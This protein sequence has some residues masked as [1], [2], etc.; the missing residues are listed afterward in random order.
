MFEEIKKKIPKFNPKKFNVDFELAVIKA[1]KRVFPGAHIQGCYFHF[2]KNVIHNIGQHNLKKR[3]EDDALFAHEVRKLTSLAFVPTSK[4]AEVFDHFIESSKIFKEKK[5]KKD[6]NL[7]EFI[8][9]YFHNHYIGKIKKGQRVAG[10]FPI[11]LWNV[12]NSTVDGKVACRFLV[13]DI[14]YNIILFFFS[15][16]DRTNNTSEGWNNAFGSSVCKHPPIFKFIN[17]VK[18]EINLSDGKI[19]KCEAGEAPPK[20]KKKHEEKNNK[21]SKCVAN[22]HKDLAM[23]DDDIDSE[24]D[25]EQV[26]VKEMGPYLRLIS[27]IAHQIKL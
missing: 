24:E 1:I 15:E 27:S 18:N 2:V 26:K 25:D 21:I 16:L 19:S 8:M 5:R 7:R 4:V 12:Y 13:L 10:Q 23:T 11:E 9:D 17:R 3:Y 22:F 20:K 6:A 14:P